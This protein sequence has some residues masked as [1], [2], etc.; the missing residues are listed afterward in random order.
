MLIFTPRF[1]SGVFSSILVEGVLNMLIASDV[2]SHDAVSDL[3]VRFFKVIFVLVLA[4]PALFSTET[5]DRILEI[6]GLFQFACFFGLVVYVL[7][8]FDPGAGN[9][10][11]EAS[12]SSARL[13]EASGGFGQ[14]IGTSIGGVIAAPMIDRSSH[15]R[16]RLK[17]FS[18]QG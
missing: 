8:V 3:M 14:M 6:A 1:G 2:L 11:A 7:A 15:D 16:G 13:R 17:T 10:T 18:G 4:I 9:M 5:Y 12:A